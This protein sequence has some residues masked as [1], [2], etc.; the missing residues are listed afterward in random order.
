MGPRAARRTEKEGREVGESISNGLID[1]LKRMRSHR[2]R[3]LFNSHRGRIAGTQPEA[4]T[5][6]DKRSS[7]GTEVAVVPIRRGCAM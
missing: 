1:A 4:G 7:C 6:P 3:K 2:L 5:Q